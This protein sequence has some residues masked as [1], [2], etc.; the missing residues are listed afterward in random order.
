MKRTHILKLSAIASALLSCVATATPMD[1][2]DDNAYR[3]FPASVSAEIE[4]KYYL[5][6]D[7]HADD[8]IWYVPK[9]GYVSYRGRGNNTRPNFNASSYVPRFG[10]W[11]ALR[12]GEAQIRMGGA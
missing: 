9:S 2:N 12:P 11:A 6:K 10:T 8:L 5:Y 4:S 7:S 1:P 3:H